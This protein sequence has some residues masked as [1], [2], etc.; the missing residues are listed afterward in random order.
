MYELCKQLDISYEIVQYGVTQD[1]RI[2]CSHTIVNGKEHYGYGGTCF[3]KD[4][5][6]LYHLF[7]KNSLHSSILEANLYTNEYKLRKD[8]D[9]LYNYDRAITQ[10]DEKVYVFIGFPYNK[11]V[12]EY[13]ISKLENNH[14]ILINEENNYKCIVNKNLFF[15]RTLL[16]SKIY[17]PKGDYLYTYFPVQSH[18]LR[19]S[20]QCVINVVEYN[21]TFQIPLIIIYEDENYNFLLHKIV[22]QN[23]NI[24][25]SLMDNLK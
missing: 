4:T 13:F 11:S 8:R 3:P 2:G 12:F 14:I 20:L 21:T 5:N 24:S 19:I 16:S 22:E 15:K 10:Y 6:S 23:K 17:L 9:W 25:L 1:P 7:H 18:N